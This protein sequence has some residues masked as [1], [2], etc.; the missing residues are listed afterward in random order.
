MKIEGPNKSSSTK[1]AAKAGARK[2]AG[3][4]SFEG[5]IGET[6]AAVAPRATTGTMA[7][8]QLDALLSIQESADGTSEE[9]A[10]K[11][12]KRAMDMLEQLDQ[13]KVGLLTGGIPREVMERLTTMIASHREKI[14]D[15]KLAEIIDEIDLR[16]QVEIAKHSM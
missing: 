3:D 1:G 7:V 14:M 2:T 16:A 12:K 11:S 5:M 13:I 8:S 10:R 15:P 4:S 6:T 9:A